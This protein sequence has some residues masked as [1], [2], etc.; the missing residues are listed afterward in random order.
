MSRKKNYRGS[1]KQK[2]KRNEYN[3]DFNDK[4]KE[5]YISKDDDFDEH[6][7]EVV[8]VVM[9]DEFDEDEANTLV[10]C[11]KKNDKWII[12]SVCSHHMTRDKINFI[13]LNFL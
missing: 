4:H 12:G 3:K 2:R 13:T 7:D 5:W 1:D 9:K 8:Y 6:D 11:V 10:T